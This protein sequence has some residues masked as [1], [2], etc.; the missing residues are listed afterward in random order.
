MFFFKTFY[1]S[2]GCINESKFIEMNKFKSLTSGL[3]VLGLLLFTSCNNN[4]KETETAPKE[5]EGSDPT[6]YNIN[7]PDEEVINLDSTRV[8]SL[9]T[10]Q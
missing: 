3:F 6:R 2:K 4:S 8:D 9:D 5:V 7:A 10:T 1:I